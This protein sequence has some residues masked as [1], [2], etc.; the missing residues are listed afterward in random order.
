MTGADAAREQAYAVVLR[1][2]ETVDD[3]DH[4]VVS[5]L[6]VVFDEATARDEVIALRTEDPHPDHLYYFEATVAERR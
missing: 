4:D 1:D 6:K 5:V 3:E 2:V